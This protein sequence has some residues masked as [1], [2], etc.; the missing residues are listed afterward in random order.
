MMATQRTAR[1]D[2]FSLIEFLKAEMSGHQKI[3]LSQRKILI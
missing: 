1:G 2:S 3:A